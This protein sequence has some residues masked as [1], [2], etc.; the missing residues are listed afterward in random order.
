M[1]ALTD[2]QDQ[3]SMTKLDAVII[4]SNYP[5]VPAAFYQRYL[6]DGKLVNC[7]PPERLESDSYGL[8]RRWLLSAPVIGRWLA[9]G[10]DFHER[11]LRVILDELRRL[12]DCGQVQPVL[13]SSCDVKSTQNVQEAFQRT[14]TKSTIGKAVVTFV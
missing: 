11:E 8:L 1:K 14:A 5:D 10:K 13:D 9:F 12:V 7:S 3:E 4:T 6:K 2:Q